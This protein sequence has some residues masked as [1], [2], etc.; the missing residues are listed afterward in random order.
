[1]RLSRSLLKNREVSLLHS[2]MIQQSTV[3][4]INCVL[5]AFVC[6]VHTVWRVQIRREVYC[7]WPIRIHNL[8]DCTYVCPTYVT[9]M[10]VVTHCSL[11]YCVFACRHANSDALVAIGLN[12]VTVVM[13]CGST[14]LCSFPGLA[15]LVQDNLCKYLFQ[16]WGHTPSVVRTLESI[17]CC[18]K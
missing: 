18:L 1:M 8:Y 12:L 14:H 2:E 16:V 3:K 10:Y 4:A 13:E 11:Y 6:T 9:D 5:T 7:I 15:S 17:P